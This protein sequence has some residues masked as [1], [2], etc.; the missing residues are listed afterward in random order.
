MGYLPLPPPKRRRIRVKSKRPLVAHISEDMA[1][2]VPKE[3]PLCRLT[4]EAKE[5]VFSVNFGR[6]KIK[7]LTLKR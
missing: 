6:K 3:I 4:R 7:P 5:R 1:G 2:T